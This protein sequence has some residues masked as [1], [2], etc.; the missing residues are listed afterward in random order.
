MIGFHSDGSVD[1]HH[2]MEAVFNTDEHVLSIINI[3]IEFSLDDVVDQNA[4]SHTDL[5]VLRVPV[6]LIGNGDTFPSVWVNGSKPLS[7]TSDDSLGE[8][9]WL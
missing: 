1:T 9:M 8:D 4:G 6:G 5:V 2:K 7:N 3:K